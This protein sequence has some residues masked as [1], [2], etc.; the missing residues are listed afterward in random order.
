MHNFTMA[1]D[2]TQTLGIFGA[3]TARSVPHILEKIFFSL[4]YTSFKTCMNVSETWR[5]LLSTASYEKRLDELWKELLI[6]KPVIE[7]ELHDASKKGDT[8]AVEKLCKHPV[9]D[10][11]VAIRLSPWRQST[12]LM[13]A[14]GGGHEEVVRVLLKAGAQV[15]K[16]DKYRISPLHLAA[17]R[18]HVDVVKL[19][20]E[21]GAY[22]DQASSSGW[23]SLQLAAKN[24]DHDV[25]KVLLDRGASVNIADNFGFTPLFYAITLGKQAMDL[26]KLLVERG[27]NV[28]KQ[29]VWGRT[30]LQEAKHLG[31]EELAEEIT[32]IFLKA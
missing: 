11:N 3:T 4:D 17:N 19:L 25:C 12:P 21:S 20:L 9:V 6:E 28:N 30:P 23:T 24:G 16:T 32:E 15:N 27:A 5:K 29:N 31:H 2:I 13:E 14:A 22:Y 1:C 26:I 18:G 8:E 10:V 7:K